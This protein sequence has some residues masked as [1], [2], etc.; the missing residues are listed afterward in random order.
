MNTVDMNAIIDAEYTAVHTAVD[1]EQQED[2]D[3]HAVAVPGDLLLLP[4]NCSRGEVIS[5]LSRTIPANE[6]GLPLF[7]FRSDL[8]DLDKA[9]AY[10]HISQTESDGAVTPLGYADG[11]P[12]LQN[13]SPFWKRLPHEPQNTYMAFCR[14]LELAEEEGIRLLD[15]LAEQESLSIEQLREWSYEFYWSSRARA[16]DLFIVAAD[17]KRRENRVR[18][19]ENRHYNKAGELLEKIL[20]RFENEED[21]VNQLSSKDL[22]DAFEQMVKIQRLSL[23]LT[24]ANASTINKELSAPATSVEV[25]LRQLTKNVGSGENAEDQANRLALLM[26]D[27][28]TALQIQ[29]LIVKAT[30]AGDR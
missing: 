23:G 6:Y 27:E 8:L 18:K 10:G 24:G 28:N 5:H 26:S 15:S 9:V 19:S 1:Q 22:L 29:E 2:N 21:L 20:L 13:G 16:Y 17:A 11:F 14:F 4:T 7:Y 25:I 30:G 3:F 12:T